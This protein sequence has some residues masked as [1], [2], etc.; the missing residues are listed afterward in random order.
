MNPAA[1]VTKI[2]ILCSVII[3]YDDVRGA[4]HRR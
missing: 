1:P 3:L 4:L 2:R